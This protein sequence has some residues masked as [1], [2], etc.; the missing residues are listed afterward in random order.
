MC[1]FHESTCSGFGD[2]LWTDNPIYLSSIDYYYY[3]Y[4]YC[5]Y[6]CYYYY[7]YYYY[8]YV[9]CFGL[10]NSQQSSPYIIATHVSLHLPWHGHY[11]IPHRARFEVE[12]INDWAYLL[13]SVR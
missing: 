10:K 2:S 3:S 9:P 4:Y 7:Y 6:Y 8:Y 13:F 1:E 5:S 12:L 11:I